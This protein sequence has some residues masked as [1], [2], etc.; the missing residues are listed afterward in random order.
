MKSKISKLAV[1]A[2]F[3]LAA[4]SANAAPSYTFTLLEALGGGSRIVSANK[5]N[6][7]NQ[8]VG[9]TG[10][11]F[12][13]DRATLWSGSNYYSPQELVTS[14]SISLSRALDIN[15]SGN[16]VGWSRVAGNEYANLW[17]IN[18]LTVSQL[19]SSVSLIKAAVINDSSL[20]SI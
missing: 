10:N 4:V 15:N 12:G 2:L 19:P 20:F 17:R 9:Y 18:N 16:I 11:N 5:I 13:V 14:D 8:I 6:D 7:S 3:S 1:A